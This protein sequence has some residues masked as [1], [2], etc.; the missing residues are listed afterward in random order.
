MGGITTEGGSQAIRGPAAAKEGF[1]FLPER[2]FLLGGGRV[3]KK[4]KEK[5]HTK[6]RKKIKE[7][8][9]NEK[10]TKQHK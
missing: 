10:N 8:K 3:Q 7:N 4:K 1:P 6:N 9:K 2:A 5:K